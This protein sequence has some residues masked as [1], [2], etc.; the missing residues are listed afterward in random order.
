[1]RWASEPG[2]REI[3]TEGKSSVKSTWADVELVVATG[4]SSQV[5][6][7]RDSGVQ[8]EMHSNAAGLTFTTLRADELVR[9][10]DNF[11]VFDEGVSY[12]ET[13]LS[14]PSEE[15]GSG[16]CASERVPSFNCSTTSDTTPTS[17]ATFVT[18][19][20]EQYAVAER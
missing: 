18:I 3:E 5:L 10:I 14:V 12:I 16:R 11:C 13:R 8:R 4:W 9:Y 15:S 19:S 1:M 6:H 7:D 20:E 17:P 2:F